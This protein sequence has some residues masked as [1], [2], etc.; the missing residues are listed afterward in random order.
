MHPHLELLAGD[1]LSTEDVLSDHVSLEAISFQ[2]EKAFG[3]ELEQEITALRA[4]RITSGKVK[5]SK[6]SEITFKH[7]GLMIAYKGFEDMNAYIEFPEVDKNHPFFGSVGWSEY[8][9]NKATDRLHQKKKIL[10]FVVDLNKGRVGGVISE[11][12]HNSSIGLPLLRGDHG[13]TVKECVA[14]ML[15]E[16]G[17]ALSFYECFFRTASTNYLMTHMAEDLMG[18]A[19]QTKRAYV[20]AEYRKEGFTIASAA[21]MAKSATEDEVRMHIINDNVNSSKSVMGINIYDVRGWEQLA[22]QYATR[23]GY[24]KDIVSGLDRLYSAFG[25]PTKHSWVMNVIGTLVLLGAGPAGWAVIIAGLFLT[26]TQQRIYD[27]PKKRF[28]VIRKELIANLKAVKDKNSRKQIS[29]EIDT[30]DELLTNY[31]DYRSTFQFIQATF[32]L[33]GGRRIHRSITAQQLTEHFANSEAR[34]LAA[35]LEE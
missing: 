27:D 23:W 17:H 19:D 3:K 25:M 24:G 32:G 2:L 35:R 10:E 22:D 26:D 11:I 6:L 9:E 28:E 13:F 33:M 14:I 29:S 16:I 20:L 7:T 4:D 15:H 8:L 12:P 21:E 31:E 34:L 30:I 18:A 1:L 5:A